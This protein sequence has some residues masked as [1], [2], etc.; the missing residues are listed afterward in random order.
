MSQT[1]PS[2]TMDRRRFLAMFG[3][4]AA[5]S[6]TALACGTPPNEQPSLTQ[7][8]APTAN[9]NSARTLVVI[10]LQGGNDG[11]SMLTPYDDAALH[12][13]RPG[14]L[15]PRDELIEAD[16]RFGWH[17]ALA[18]VVGAGAAGVVG[19]GSD[20]PSFSHFEM[21]NRWWRGDS[22][23]KGEWTS[24]IFGRMCDQ[25]DA[26]DPVTGLSLA[27]GPSPSLTSEKAVT[28]GL[29]HPDAN[30]FLQED[31]AWFRALRSAHQTMAAV[32][33][34]SSKSL[35]AAQGG[36]H[37]AMLF[38]E[39]LADASLGDDDT[40]P[41]TDLGQQLRFG[42][43]V[44]ALDVGIRVLHVRQGG[45]DT[46]SGQNWRYDELMAEFNDATT[47]FVDGLKQRGLWEDTL[48]MTTSEFGRRVAEN[49]GGTDHGG[50]STAMLIG[51]GLGGVHGEPCDL[52]RLN[53]GNLVA[54]TRFDD[55]YAT[56]ASGWF[57]LDLSDLLPSGA[58]P[59]FTM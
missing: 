4:T 5:A 9:A 11:L 26:G 37:D 39:S 40:Y 57:G 49:D 34:E 20:D 10:E 51:A 30:W 16:A 29:V 50:A 18:G 52:T 23:A 28:V 1:L 47:V 46:H 44:L 27:G 55:Y 41:W 6:A 33:D 38:S 24:G 19:I 25:L 56:V 54:T 36:L 7:R 12:S 22:R 59:I 21:E 17:P 32:T 35:Q 48:I 2:A 14:L 3:A 13:A 53:D 8:S 15:T 43:E 31:A 58:E 42:V 45:Y